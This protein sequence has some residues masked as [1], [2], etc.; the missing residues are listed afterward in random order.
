MK[1]IISPSKTKKIRNINCAIEGRTPEFP[2]IT[3]KIVERIASFETEEIMKKFRLKEDK[4]KKLLNFYKNYENE[5]NG[6]S[7]ASY[8]GIAYKSMNIEE[9]NEKDLKFAEENAVILSALYGILTPFTYIKEYRLDMVNSIFEEK[10]LYEVWKRPVS[11]YFAEEDVIVNLASKEYSRMLEMDKAAAGK[12]ISLEFLDDADGK[13]K[14]IST[15]SK[16]MRGFTLNYI[17][18]NRIRD[19]EKL[20]NVSLNGYFFSAEK[21]DG[22]KLVYIKKI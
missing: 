21:S 20:K 17:V 4:A 15:N 12:M 9:F 11:G 8:S 13:L 3:K 7:L 5:K 22:K 6:I 10:S 19:I 18:K 2:D 1:I 14:Q 16:K